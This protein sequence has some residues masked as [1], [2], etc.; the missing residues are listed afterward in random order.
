MPM[1]GRQ[2]GTENAATRPVRLG[3][4]FGMPDEDNGSSNE[5]ED[6]HLQ[7]WYD[8]DLPLLAEVELLSARPSYTTC[9]VTDDGILP[10]T[11]RLPATPAVESGLANFLAPPPDWTA[12]PRTADEQW[13]THSRHEA[14]GFKGVA[15]KRIAFNVHARAAQI[16]PA[17]RAEWGQELLAQ[18]I[19][20]H[21]D[22]WWENVRTWLEICTNQRLT[23]LGQEGD[24]WL[25]PHTRTSIWAVDDYN[26]ARHEVKVGGTV[27]RGPERV[28]GVTPEILQGCAALAA[29]TPP[30]AWRLL[31]D[32]RALQNADQLRRAV[33]DAATAAEL[34][35]TKR[36]DDLL[37]N[38]ADPKRRKTLAEAKTLGGKA[39]ALR[40]ELPA[41]FHADLV[42]RRNNAVHEG[43]EVRYPE[44]EA[45]F[46]A[47]LALVERVFPLPTPPGSAEP[48]MCFWSRAT[49]PEIFNSRYGPSRV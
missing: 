12:T 7:W 31:R 39:T 4:G 33:I 23:Q 10:V 13:G 3:Y 38:E 32:A 28:I 48:L 19:L 15:I 5:D 29:T 46:C 9:L 6:V 30:L 18:Q 44:W 43:I 26:G 24:D 8:L 17:I 1:S 22:T 35:A 14:L 27:I 2:L 34:A 49:R 36:I 42:R 37:A 16:D 11:L 45:A 20:H 47:A 25:N 21:I 40:D 41:N